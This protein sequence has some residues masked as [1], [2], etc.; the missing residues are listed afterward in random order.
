MHIL[1]RCTRT[2]ASTHLCARCF[3]R[4]PRSVRT[5]DLEIAAWVSTRALLSLGLCY[6]E[7]RARAVGTCAHLAALSRSTALGVWLQSPVSSSQAC[8]Q[9]VIIAIL[10][11]NSKATVRI[12]ITS[13]G[14][15]WM[16]KIKPV[17]CK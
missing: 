13:N 4:W 7:P 8:S 10:L 6:A 12:H 9:P 11:A 15:Q 1:Q 17:Y 14:Q 16:R 2:V 5:R 3:V